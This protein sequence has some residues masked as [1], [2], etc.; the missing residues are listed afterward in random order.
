MM[1][2]MNEVHDFMS[3]FGKDVETKWG[4][5]STNLWKIK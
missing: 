2:E 5:T 1:E 4:L 3:K